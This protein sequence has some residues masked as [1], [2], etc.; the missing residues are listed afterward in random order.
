MRTHLLS[1]DVA[2]TVY[3]N[4]IQGRNKICVN[5]WFR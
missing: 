2:I 1:S 4:L 3:A 5:T